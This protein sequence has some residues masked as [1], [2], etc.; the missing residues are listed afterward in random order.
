MGKAETNES[1]FIGVVHRDPE[2][3]ERL[4]QALE[5]LEPDLITVEVSPYAIAFR[6]QNGNRLRKKLKK[7]LSTDELGHGEI[8]G[9][10]ETLKIP[11]EARA[12]EHYVGE[13]G[14]VVELVDDSGISMAF[15]GELEDEVLSAENLR[16]LLSKP[17]I[18][19]RKTIESFYSRYRAL[20]TKEPVPSAMLGFSSRRLALLEWRDEMMEQRIRCL[21]RKHH[22]NR[23]VHVGGVVHLLR[24]SGLRFL[25]ERF[26]GD[27]ARRFFLDES[28]LDHLSG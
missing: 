7:I 28:V 9:I 22:P 12:A 26:A 11:F 10:A 25:W 8:Q 5:R 18:P 16:G 14:A 23:W 4:Y 6:R 20:M 15:L 1:V 27:H 13:H 24:V 19:L 21:W 17:D 2:G 3:E